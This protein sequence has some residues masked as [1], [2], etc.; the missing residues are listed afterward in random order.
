M[1]RVVANSR[2]RWPNATRP[3]NVMSKKSRNARR[4]DCA[5]AQREGE[6]SARARDLACGWL[7]NGVL[8]APLSGDRDKRVKRVH[9]VASGVRV[10][11]VGNWG[12]ECLLLV[13]GTIPFASPCT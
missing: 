9:V 10:N 12:I 13:C 7:H 4:P 8:E 3:D 6:E 11:R 1:L 5:G 2:S